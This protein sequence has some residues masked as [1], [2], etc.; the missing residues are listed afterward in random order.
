[1]GV[2]SGV[3]V[4]MRGVQA[5][6]RALSL[7]PASVRQLCLPSAL[8]MGVRKIL[9]RK[10]TLQPMS[11]AAGP[12]Q[13]SRAWSSGTL[14]PIVL[15]QLCPSSPSTFPSWASVSSVMQCGD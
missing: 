7:L 4:Q 15:P 11:D 12:A 9:F 3:A 6:V 8:Y 5:G 13:S 2:V 1:M 14:I 10:S